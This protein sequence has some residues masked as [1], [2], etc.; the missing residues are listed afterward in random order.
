M[1]SFELWIDLLKVELSKP[2]PGTDAQLIMSPL[3]RLP[4]VAD[5]SVRNSGVLLLLYP[6]NGNV[7]TVFIKRTDYPGF[8]GGQISLPGGMFEKGDASLSATALRETEEEIGLAGKEVDLIGHLTALHIPVSNNL[9]FP[10]VAVC[11]K[12]P[13][14]VPE[15]REVQYVIETPVNDLLDEV[16]RKSEIL[17]IAGMS[18]NVPYFDIQ[19]HHIWGATAMMVNEFLEVV[20][21]II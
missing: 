12:R 14:F 3:M 8:H 9:V 16:N 20:R 15:S 11:L 2:L 18:M 6:H 17:Q 10:F 13:D 19:G 4:A 1:L 5:R 21:R 7:Y